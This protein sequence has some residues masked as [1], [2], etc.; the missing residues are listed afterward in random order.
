[1]LNTISYNKHFTGSN[2]Q[3]SFKYRAPNFLTKVQYLLGLGCWFTVIK[4][5]TYLFINNLFRNLLKQKRNVK[6]LVLICFGYLNISYVILYLNILVA[7]IVD[8]LLVFQAFG[9]VLAFR[10]CRRRRLLLS[11]F[12]VLFSELASSYSH[13]SSHNALLWTTRSSIWRRERDMR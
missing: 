13:G 3:A 11:L 7:V 6:K 12:V 1:M 4:I 5:N 10:A 9:W 8:F 2:R